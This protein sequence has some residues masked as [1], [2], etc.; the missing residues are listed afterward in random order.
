MKSMTGQRVTLTELRW[1]DSEI[2]FGWIN[3]AD[4]MRFNAPYGPV[5]QPRHEEW[6]RALTADPA[7]IIF[8]VRDKNEGRLVG[9]VQLIDLHPIHRTAEL[10]IRIGSAVD[11]GRG[12]GS[13][14]VGLVTAFG[15][16]HRNLQRIWLRV[17]SDNPRAIRAYEKAGFTVEGTLRRACFIDGGWKDEVVMAILRGTE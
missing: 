7:R 4:V 16:E 3:D 2:L 15:F 9:T 5:H 10:T 17:F 11:R 14:A 6:F 8:A 13:E 1:Q 12:F